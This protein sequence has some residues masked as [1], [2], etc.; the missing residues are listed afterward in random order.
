M[1]LRK[2]ATVSFFILLADLQLDCKTKQKLIKVRKGRGF[3]FNIKN[4]QKGPGHDQLLA[5]G[6]FTAPI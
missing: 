4:V 1:D 6:Q 3:F 2:K 5:E